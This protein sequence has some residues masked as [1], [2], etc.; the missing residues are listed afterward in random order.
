M[1]A[2]SSRLHGLITEKTTGPLTYLAGSVSPA[3]AAIPY[4]CYST[5]LLPI[6]FPIYKFVLNDYHSFLSLGPGGTPS[7]FSGYLWVTFLKIFFARSDTYV[8]PSLTPYEHPARGYLKEIPHRRGPRPLV[9]GIA[10]HRQTTQKGCEEMQNA[11]A[12]GLKDLARTNSD[13]LSTGISCFEKHNL[14]LFFNPQS[15][16][17]QSPAVSFIELATQGEAHTLSNEPDPVH[18][19]CSL[20]AEICH[21]HTTDSSMHLTLHPSDAAMVISHGWGERHPLAGRGPWVP[22]GFVMVYAPRG[23]EEVEILMKIVR[24]GAWWVGGCILDDGNNLL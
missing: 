23:K 20:P 19:S 12:A 24:A 11:L 2:L 17:I 5:L 13:L 10:P 15:V 16:D 22:R 18:A 6:V 14:A 9:A 3:N 7:T 8:P 21:L 4:L 1:A